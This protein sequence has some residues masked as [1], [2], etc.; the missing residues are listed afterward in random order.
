MQEAGASGSCNKPGD[1]ATASLAEQEL[2]V[3]YY[4]YLIN[5]KGDARLKL[6][7]LSLSHYGGVS[8]SL[9]ARPPMETQMINFEDA[10]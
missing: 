5:G 3:V 1:S 4:C 2:D 8:H 10:I 7:S 9:G 6:N